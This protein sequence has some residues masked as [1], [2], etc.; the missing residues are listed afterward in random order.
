VIAEALDAA[1]KGAGYD[2]VIVGYLLQ[3]AEELKVSGGSGATDLRRRTSRLI[4]AMRPETLRR[5]LE[6][7]GDFAQR[8]K[9]AIDAAHGVAVDAVLEIV[10]AAADASNQTVSHSL[11]R[12]LS[13]LAAHAEHGVVGVRVNADAAL[14]DQVDHLLKGWTLEDPNPGG[15]GKALQAMSRTRAIVTRAG[16]ERF[17]AEDERLV[18]MALELDEVGPRL[19]EA[20]VRLRD[21][22][23][24][25]VVLHTLDQAPAG[26]AAATAVRQMTGTV[27]TLEGLLVRE[28]IDFVLVDRVVEQLGFEAVNPL[29][30]ALAVTENRAVRRALLDRL[31]VLPG[32]IGPLLVPRLED[33]RWYV[34][35]NLLQLL[36]RL[37]KLPE[38]FSPADYASD[39]DP[40]VRRESVRLQLSSETELALGV[41]NALSDSDEQTV[42]RG[43]QAAQEHPDCLSAVL[44]YVIALAL[45]ARAP[46]GVRVPALRCLGSSTAPEALET[47]LRFTEGG[48]TLFRRPRLPPTSP[49]LVAALAVLA[50]RWPSDPRA[51]AVLTRAAQSSDPMVRAAAGG[52]DAPT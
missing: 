28:P 29:L 25:G 15:Y 37:P 3:I 4:R 2:Q 23:R 47:L 19:G 48:R 24:L 34:R 50:Q 21:A 27:E 32:D 17:G 18:Q 11:A 41:A 16:D 45:D 26:T 20:V 46:T 7:G 35:R 51:Q 31:A 52:R 9:F 30:D 1:P 39:A 10:R 14:R 22:G 13:K 43:L 40:R 49:E 6:M 36:A 5:L 44:S 38:G 33:K 42:R 12:M 8:Q